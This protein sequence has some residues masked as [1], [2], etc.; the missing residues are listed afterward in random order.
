MK[1]TTELTHFK[2][3]KKGRIIC[4]VSKQGLGAVL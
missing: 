3:K 1:Q 4:D 2:R